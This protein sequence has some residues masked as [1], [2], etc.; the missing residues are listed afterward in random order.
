MASYLVTT[1]NWNSSSFWSGIAETSEGHSLDF[2]GL[3]SSYSV[4]FDEAAEVVTISDGTTTFTVGEPGND[5]N[6]GV[7]ATSRMA[8]LRPIQAQ[9][10][11]CATSD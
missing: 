8:R 3:P 5:T 2:S 1:T 11:L 10:M 6:D 7:A 9:M 4:D